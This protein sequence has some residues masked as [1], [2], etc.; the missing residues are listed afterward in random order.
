MSDSISHSARSTLF[1]CPRLY[2][3]KYVQGLSLDE[4]ISKPLRMGSAFSDAL[5]Y[6]NTNV[7]KNYYNELIFD[8]SNPRLQEEMSDESLVVATLYDEYAKLYGEGDERELEFGPIDIAGWRWNGFIDGVDAND[9]TVLIEN[10]LK[11]RWSPQD[12][13]YVNKLDDQVTGYFSAYSKL[14]GISADDLT[15]QYRVT[16][17]PGIR[18]KKATKTKPAETPREYTARLKQ[19]ILTRPNHYNQ[20]EVVTRTQEQVNE[21]D[22]ELEAA[23]EYLEFMK[24]QGEYPR[25]TSGCNLYGRCDMFDLCAAKD[26]DELEKAMEKYVEREDK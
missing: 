2:F 13:E 15:M 21:W 24:E 14:T 19:D 26:T 17:K 6:K 7:V 4:T 25:N 5:E 23:V 11:G 20:V 1:K 9:E 3:L 8:E 22:S 18:R 12:I 16:L 10:K